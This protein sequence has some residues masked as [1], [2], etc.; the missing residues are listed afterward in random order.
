MNKLLYVFS[1]NHGNRIIRAKVRAR[2]QKEAEKT[3]TQKHPDLKIVHVTAIDPVVE[4]S[5][6]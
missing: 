3:V 4:R 5:F 1:L 6:Y 2:S